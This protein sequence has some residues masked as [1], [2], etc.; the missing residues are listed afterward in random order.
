MSDQVIVVVKKPTLTRTIFDCLVGMA[1]LF[2]AISY[3]LH[4]YA[5]YAKK[6]DVANEFRD[7]KNEAKKAADLANI[8]SSKIATATTQA[9]AKI[10]TVTNIANIAMEATKSHKGKCACDVK[11]MNDRLDAIEKYDRAVS[12][13]NAAL[14]REIEAK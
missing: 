7:A 3:N 14:Q 13:W 1:V 2:L 9:D 6:Q 11:A 4:M 5:P 10:A 12:A 8:N